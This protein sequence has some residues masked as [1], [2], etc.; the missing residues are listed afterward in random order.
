MNHKME[1]TEGFTLSGTQL[2]YS[3]LSTGPYFSIDSQ[4]MLR[5]Q[6]MMQADRKLPELS[7]F[8]HTVVFVLL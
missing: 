4:A 8:E 7:N 5:N 1:E 6:K 3:N 2:W